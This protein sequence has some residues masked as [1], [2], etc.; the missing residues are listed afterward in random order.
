[1][2]KKKLPMVVDMR[3]ESDHE[4]PTRIIIVPKSNRIDKD[5]LMSHL[6]ATTDLEKNHRVN[7]N[8]IGIDRKP[9]VKDIVSLLKEWLKFR[10]S[11]VKRRLQHRLKH[12]LD[13]LH[14]L[15]GLLIAFLNLLA[16]LYW[17]RRGHRRI[18]L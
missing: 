6:F 2:Q 12:L 10:T 18:R 13:R 14:I 11:T 15:D 7:F 5:A 9:Q 3:D 17:C 4:N 16:L 1:M 8:V